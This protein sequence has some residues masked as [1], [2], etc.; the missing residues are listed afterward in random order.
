[1]GE[2]E[3][4]PMMRSVSGI[5]AASATGSVSRTKEAKYRPAASLMTVTEVGVAGRVRDHFTFTAPIFGKLRRPLSVMFQRAL[6]VNRID[7]R[8]SLRD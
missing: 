7:C 8:A 1:V 4:I 2:A 3:I 5:R 6:A